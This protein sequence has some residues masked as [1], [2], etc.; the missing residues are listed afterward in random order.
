MLEATVELNRLP[1][2]PEV[3]SSKINSD[4][5]SPV[6]DL[7]DMYLIL[8]LEPNDTLIAMELAKRLRETNRLEE[9]ARILGSVVKIDYR[10]ETLNALAQVEYQLDRM[11]LAF[12]HLQQALVIAPEGADGLFEV[13]KT[14]GN[15]FVRHGDFDSAEDNYFKAH[16]LNPSSDILHVNLGTLAM[17]KQDWDGA[18]EKFRAALQ[19]NRANDKA[20]VG[21]ALGH[22]TKGDW[23]LAWGNVEAALEYNPLNEVA[24]GLALEWST[25]ESREFRAL[26]LIRNFLVEGGWNEKLSLAFVWLSYRRG[27]KAAAKLELERLL[28][29]NPFNE[30]ALA[31]AEDLRKNP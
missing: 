23:E 28:A 5:Q 4:R 8:Q 27:E 15:I 14:L 31:L 20:W 21:L 18:L 7:E 2:T 24:L 3:P 6:L 10:F 26:E 30:Q 29:V 12:D 11:D 17:Q 16:R 1:L 22:R 9:S 13:F 19:F 25:Y